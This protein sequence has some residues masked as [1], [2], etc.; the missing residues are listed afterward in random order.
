[1]GIVT[2][3]SAES[4]ILNKNETKKQNNDLKYKKFEHLTL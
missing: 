3:R 2:L 1:M 4:V